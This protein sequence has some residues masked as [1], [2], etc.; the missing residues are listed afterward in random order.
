M[1]ICPIK[2]LNKNLNMFLTQISH[3]ILITLLW[4]LRVTTHVTTLTDPYNYC[5]TYRSFV[6]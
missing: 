1:N 3:T 6:P 4:S 5:L 2:F